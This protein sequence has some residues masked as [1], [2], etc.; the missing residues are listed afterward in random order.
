MVK[1]PVCNTT[2]IYINET[3]GVFE[4][5]GYECNVI[6]QIARKHNVKEPHQRTLLKNLVCEAEIIQ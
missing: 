4:C 5:G 3:N 1:C 2:M 6:V